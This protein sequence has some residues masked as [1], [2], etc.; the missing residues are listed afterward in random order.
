MAKLFRISDAATLALH[1]MALLASA[2][3]GRLSVREVANRLAASRAHLS[4]VLQRLARAG[5]VTS[6]RGPRGG[7]SLA[8]PA[9]DATLLDV[10]EAI[11]GPLED[12]TCLLG[13]PVC[14]GDSCLLGDLVETVNLHVRVRLAGTRLCDVAG[15]LTVPHPGSGA[16]RGRL[17]RR[18]DRPRS[19]KRARPRR[20]EGARGAR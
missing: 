1:T 17:S 19:R 5:L 2:E 7:F 15:H 9:E 13:A 12:S 14:S 4:K 6:L 3:P 10:Y 16:G 18:A 11:E 20:Q 8:R